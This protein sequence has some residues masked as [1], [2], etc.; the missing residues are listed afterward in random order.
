M[1]TSKAR[2]LLKWRPRYDAIK[3][4]QLTVSAQSR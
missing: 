1:D 2:R 4:L 3:T